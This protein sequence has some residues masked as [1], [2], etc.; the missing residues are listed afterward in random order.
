MSIADWILLLLVILGGLIGYYR[1]LRPQM[2]LITGIVLGIIISNIFGNWAEQIFAILV[3]E[4]A[5]WHMGALKVAIGARFILFLFVYLSVELLFVLMHAYLDRIKMKSLSQYWGIPASLA[6]TL[7]ICSFSL[8]G[9]FML[10]PRNRIITE[11]HFADNI[12]FDMMMDL[13]P[14]AMGCDTL[15]S[16][17]IDISQLPEKQ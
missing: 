3:P 11:E 16:T 1:G 15:P 4:S 8:D 7:V 14:A 6:A 13:M 5:K 2:G 10:S 9:I 12:P 17:M